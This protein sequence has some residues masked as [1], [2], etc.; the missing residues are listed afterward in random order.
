VQAT[1]G[2]TMNKRLFRIV[3]NAHRQLK[4]AIPEVGSVASLAKAVDGAS[5]VVTLAAVTVTVFG[6]LSAAH[7]Q[8]IA[9]IQAP[10]TQQPTIFSAGNGTPVVN[11]QTPSAAGV[12]RNSFNQFDVQ[13]KGVVLNNGQMDTQTKQAGWV[14][15]NPWLVTGTAK[16]ILNEVSSNQPSH[17]N[18][19][20]EVAGQRADVIVANPAGISVNGGGFINASKGIL[21]T[22]NAVFNAAGGIDSYR[23]QGGQVTID[24]AGLDMRTTDYG[25]I[26]ARAVQVNA[27]LWANELKVVTGANQID[28]AGLDTNT[29]PKSTPIEGS[30]PTP[31]FALDVAQIGG[32]YAGKIYLVGTEAGLGVRN[33]GS[34]SANGAQ[35][36]ELVLTTNGWLTNTASG[37]MQAQGDLRIAAQGDVTNRG[38]FDGTLTRIEAANVTNIGTGRIYGDHIAIKAGTMTNTVE[39]VNGT[40]QSATVAAR[41]RLDIAATHVINQD[42]ALMFSNGDMSIGAGLDSK[43]QA[44]GAAQSFRNGSAMV[45]VNGHLTINAD[46][47]TNANDHFAYKT[48][49][50]LINAETDSNHRQNDVLSKRQLGIYEDNGDPSHY[51]RVFD[52]YV[53]EPLVTQ[54][55]PGQITAAGNITLTGRTVV[56]QQSKIIAGGN[57][58]ATAASI[59]N[60][61][62]TSQRIIRDVG[63]QWSWGVVGGHD[64][65]DLGWHWV[66][67]WGLVLTCPGKSG[68]PVVRISTWRLGEGHAKEEDLTRED[69]FAA[70][71]D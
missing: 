44:T 29:T 45:D 21:T 54:S 20:I 31:S 1:D 70:A 12:S 60:Q 15:A 23:V 4:M 39:T 9:N 2:V 46:N 51:Y 67:D 25:A 59:D 69:H 56:N 50:E 47:I 61:D 13:S 42:H 63:N 68:L 65:W 52:R 41:D 36:G 11:I 43:D 66:L 57:L 7:A 48:A 8:I 49:Q 30:G 64:E 10:K 24:G 17:I 27:G 58:W 40:S 28:A 38:A 62:V 18:G 35:G 33:A 6:S 34:L 14:Q 3:F 26:L 55:D 37:A 53:Y 22:G 16:V 5:T 19:Y 71:A 32:M